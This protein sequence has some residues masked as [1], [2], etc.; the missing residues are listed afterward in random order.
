MANNNLGAITR[1]LAPRVKNQIQANKFVYDKWVTPIA[2][3]MTDL[4]WGNGYLTSKAPHSYFD[5]Q[6]T[7][8]DINVYVEGAYTEGD[9]GKIPIMEFNFGIQQQKQPVYGFWSWTYDAVMRGTR[10]VNGMFRLV[11]KTTDYMAN[12]IA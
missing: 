9:I 6:F 11:T 7:G 12:L 3:P 4:Q 8:Q 5:Y 10:I 2:D 1:A